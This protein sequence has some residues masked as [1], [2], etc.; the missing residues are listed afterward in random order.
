M[1]SGEYV[2]NKM[3]PLFLRNID[4]ICLDGVAERYYRKDMEKEFIFISVPLLAFYRKLLSEDCESNA[5]WLIE[6][7]MEKL[8]TRKKCALMTAEEQDRYIEGLAIDLCIPRKIKEN[9]MGKGCFYS[10]L[11]TENPLHA[12]IFINVPLELTTGRDGIIE[13]SD[14][15]DALFKLLFCANEDCASIF[16]KLLETLGNDN[17]ELF[18]LNYLM[19]NVKDFVD[20]IC[21]LTAEE[22]EAFNKQLEQLHIF[23]AYDKEELVSLEYAFSVD[24][25]IYQYL[26]EIQNPSR[27]IKGWMQENSENAGS[28]DLL[29]LSTVDEC[30]KVESFAKI[31]DTTPGYY[32]LE[33]DGRDLMLE[34]MSEEYGYVNGDDEDE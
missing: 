24:R 6:D 5:Q 27:D 13:D 11:P 15:N 19:P 1:V 28:L 18:I 34:Y 2:G 9:N 29:I 14:Y 7:V 17:R 26:K 4:S 3:S 12:T 31:V 8:K 25:I 10:T 23:K 21:N 33:E 30:E 32:P 20:E 16:N 22:H